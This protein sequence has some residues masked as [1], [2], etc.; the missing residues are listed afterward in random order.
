MRKLFGVDAHCHLLCFAFFLSFFFRRHFQTPLRQFLVNGHSSI[1]GHGDGEQRGGLLKM[2][3][4][5]RLE[6]RELTLDALVDMDAS[7][8]SRILR[9]GT[10]G[11]TVKKCLS[12]IPYLSVEAKIQPITR[13]VLRIEMELTPEFVWSDQQHGQAEASE[14]HTQRSTHSMRCDGDI[15]RALLTDSLSPLCCVRFFSLLSLQLL[16]LD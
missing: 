4:I 15:M 8:I 9:H 12:H 13:S 3:T 2:P 11:H 1:K 6:E 5:M 16:D 14:K 7:E 10:M